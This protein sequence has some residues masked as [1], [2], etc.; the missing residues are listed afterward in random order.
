MKKDKKYVIHSWFSLESSVFELISEL[1][2]LFWHQSKF[3]KFLCYDVI[4]CQEISKLSK[5]KSRIPDSAPSASRGTLQRCFWGHGS[6][7]LA[8]AGHG[9]AVS[10][11]LH[12]PCCFVITVRIQILEVLS[13]NLS[14][15]LCASGF[16]SMY[17]SS[18]LPCSTF[19]GAIPS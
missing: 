2:S 4:I 1:F 15:C 3:G 12:I 19:F 16:G 17:N 8:A 13:L 6:W 14:S 10:T 9:F 7:I 18:Q 5:H 11:S